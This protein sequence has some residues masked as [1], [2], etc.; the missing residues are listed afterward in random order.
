[1]DRHAIQLSNITV[2]EL[3]IKILD[4]E[5]FDGKSFPRD[6]SLT[7]SRSD[8]DAEDKVI[9]VR[10][11]MNLQPESEIIDRPFEMRIKIAGHFEVDEDNFPMEQIN[12]F[13]ENNAPVL[14]IPYIR[15]QAYS[16]SIRAGVDPVLFPL[17]QVP[18]FRITKK[19][20][21]E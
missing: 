12:N 18:I 16:L 20:V 19:E 2:D 10:L 8:Y 7:V 1:M 9:S 11:E 13:A 3:Y 15:E 4:R 21:K 17:V 5:S 6:F 14:L